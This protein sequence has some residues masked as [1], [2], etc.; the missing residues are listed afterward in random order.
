MHPDELDI[1]VTVVRRLLARQFPEWANLPIEPV[2]PRGT[3]NALFRLGDDM[4]ARLPRHE[5]TVETL[6]RERQWLP[7]LAPQLPLD[8]PISLAAGQPS[9]GYPWTWSIYCWLEGQAA[10]ESPVQDIREA[11]LDLA[12]F[13]RALHRID[14]AGGPPPAPANFL[15]GAPL[16]LLVPSLRAFVAALRDPIDS[17]IAAFEAGLESPEWTGPPVWIHGDLDARNLLVRD[18]RLSAV[19]DFGCVGV[20]DPACDVAVAWKMLSRPARDVFRDELAVDDDTWAR[21]RGWIAWQAIGALSYYTLETNPVLVR[22]AERWL[23]E[24]VVD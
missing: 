22:E 5:R 18:G 13:I 21:A 6:I 10:I 24:L 16:R 12:R 20:G 11:A 15:R 17:A 3:D 8:V 19:I 7:A 23:E 4:V 1:T 14:A 9:D 2:E